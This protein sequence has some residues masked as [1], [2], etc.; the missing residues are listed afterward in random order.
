M[1]SGTLNLLLE[2][3]PALFGLKRVRVYT[4]LADNWI[5]QLSHDYLNTWCPHLIRMAD[6]EPHLSIIRVYSLSIQPANDVQSSYK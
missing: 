6:T 2:S 1:Y 5:P 4:V 3:G